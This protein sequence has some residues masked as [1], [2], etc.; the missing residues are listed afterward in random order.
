M[1]QDIVCVYSHGYFLSYLGAHWPLAA[2][3]SCVSVCNL[4]KWL[5]ITEL[6]PLAEHRC[7]RELPPVE[8]NLFR[9]FPQPGDGPGVQENASSGDLR[10][11]APFTA[12]EWRR[13]RCCRTRHSLVTRNSIR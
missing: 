2:R 10:W 3:L 1:P 7:S 13:R 8:R 9:G 12:V 5:E 4:W 11:C 6:E